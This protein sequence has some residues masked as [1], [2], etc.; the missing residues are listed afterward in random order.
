VRYFVGRI[1]MSIIETPRSKLLDLVVCVIF[2]CSC[3]FGLAKP[4]ETIL[5]PFMF[6]DD[7]PAWEVAHEEGSKTEHTIQFLRPGQTAENWTETLTSITFK[8]TRRLES[9]DEQIAAYEKRLVARCPDATVE[10]IRQTPNGVLFESRVV[11]CGTGADEHVM[12]R[13]LKGT[14]NRFLV[15]YI[16]REA[17]PMTTERRAEWIENLMSVEI[18]KL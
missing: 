3:V 2:L 10:I 8:K 4:T 5:L 11:N 12:I 13:I 14:S 6:V 9:V 15:Q 16:F 1:A 18:T 7:E 17:L